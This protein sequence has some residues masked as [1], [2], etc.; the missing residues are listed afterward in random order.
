MGGNVKEKAKEQV[1][2]PEKK[3]SKPKIGHCSCFT[4]FCISLSLCHL[5][6][7]CVLCLCSNL[8]NSLYSLCFFLVVFFFMSVEFAST[9]S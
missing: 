8:C 3:K 1:V 2:P 5:L 7:D 4:W 9:L 6:V